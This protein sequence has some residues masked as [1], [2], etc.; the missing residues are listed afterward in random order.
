MYHDVAASM[1]VETAG[2]PAF[3]GITCRMSELQGAVANVQLDRLDGI[4][5]DCRANR[6]QI[7]EVIHD[8]AE[9]KA[10]RLRASHDEAGDTA[11]ALILQCPDARQAEALVGA[12]RAAG[13]DTEV[14]FDPGTPDLHISYHWAPILAQRSASSPGPWAE[15][16]GEFSYGPDRW[17]RTC[18]LLSRSVHLDVSP[19][20]TSEQVDQIGAALRDALATL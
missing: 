17:T 2:T 14:M 16:E 1:R 4:I 8:E 5:A 18:E 7:V 19:D 10:V 11:I 20:L 15:Q 3:Y 13:L 9:R 12:A 6:S